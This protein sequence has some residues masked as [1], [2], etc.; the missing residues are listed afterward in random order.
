ML[1]SFHLNGRTF[2]RILS[3]DSKVRTTSYDATCIMDGSV[4][5]GYLH[6]LYNCYFC[7]TGKADHSIC[8]DKLD[9]NLFINGMH[10]CMYIFLF[11]RRLR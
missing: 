4:G 9:C 7:N 8:F 5:P 10:F 2:I 6:S 11:L 3:V 1:S